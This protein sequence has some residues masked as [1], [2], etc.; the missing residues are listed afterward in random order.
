MR[1][2][3]RNV[4][5]TKKQN[6]RADEGVERRRAANVD[7]PQT[8]DEHG[9]CD[10]G[11][12]GH[13]QLVVH[14]PQVLGKRRGAV[15]C[16]GPK[17]ASCGDEQAHH[18]KPNVD[19]DHG[20]H[21][22]STRRARSLAVNLGNRVRRTGH[23]A[24]VVDGVH[25]GDQ[26]AKA[27]GE[28]N[29]HLGN[30]PQ[31]HVALGVGN[32]LGQVR[33]NVDGPDAVRTVEH[34]RYEDEAIRVAERIAPLL[35]HE[36]VGGMRG[37]HHGDGDDGDEE[38]RNDGEDAAVVEAGHGRV[39]RADEGRGHPDRDDIDNKDV[40]CF[41]GEVWMVQGVHLN[42]RVSAVPTRNRVSHCNS[43]RGRFTTRLWGSKT[44]K[45]AAMLAAPMVYAK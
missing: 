3:G 9:R 30:D 36:V 28:P 5:A 24:K 15:A 18:T 16:Q 39:G 21:T 13:F 37:G 20:Q 17:N 34:A 35:P 25:D 1:Q 44:H 6:G 7:A 2:D 22:C 42:Y 38:A 41:S 33:D 4:R 14:A 8:A 45:M 10:G 40:P 31:R 32:L 29:G 19:D 26:V 23:G 27:R 43:N 12:H 11:D